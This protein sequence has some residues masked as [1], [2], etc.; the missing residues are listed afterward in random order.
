MNLERLFGDCPEAEIKG[1]EII[2]QVVEADSEN[3]LKPSPKWPQ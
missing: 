1:C 2:V 3:R